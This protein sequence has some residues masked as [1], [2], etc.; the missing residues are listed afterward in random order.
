VAQAKK[1]DQVSV[2][3]T[4][5]LDDGS[6]FDSSDHGEPLVFV[7]GTSQV[8]PGFENA[9]VG[10]NTGDSKTVKIAV[11]EAYGLRE[12]A[13]VMNVDRGQIPPDL[14]IEV[15]QHL[16]MEKSDGETMRVTVMS[17]TEEMV[18]LD[19]NHPLAGEDLTFDI[20]LVRI[21]E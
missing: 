18:T 14:E 8:V 4:G 3:Y 20:T 12:E 21:T 5:R 9:I 11:R 6:V 10:M 19:G 17:V 15:G 1:G 2:H 13:L 7:L 16:Q